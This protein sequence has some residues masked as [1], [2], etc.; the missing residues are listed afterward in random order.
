MLVIKMDE[1]LQ[2]LKIKLENR[3]TVSGD[4]IDLL[5]WGERH[6]NEVKIL[7]ISLNRQED[8]ALDLRG[9]QL[10]SIG[11]ALSDKSGVGFMEIIYPNDLIENPNAELII[12]GENKSKEDSIDEIQRILG[13]SYADFGTTKQVNKQ[14]A[15]QFHGW[16]RDN[17]PTAYV[18]IDIDAIH[19]SENDVN[20]IISLI[21]VKRSTAI[22]VL[23]WLPYTNDIRNYYI[24]NVFTKLANLNFY[25][26]NHSCKDIDVV[27]NTVRGFYDILDVNIE[28]NKILFEQK[29]WTAAY[30]AKY[31]S[32]IQ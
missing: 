5:I 4:N 25:T 21:E 15:D 32:E 9:D 6:Y 20:D 10:L 22:S 17:L 14:V 18:R 11:K 2:Y 3:I 28:L 19:S 31:I 12:N 26:I 23:N 16:A 24:E 27:D 29:L 13:T 7:G 8:V 30:L 1:L